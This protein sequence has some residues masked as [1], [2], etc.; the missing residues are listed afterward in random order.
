MTLIITVASPLFIIQV[1]DRLLTRAIA[2]KTEEFDANSNKSLI[3]E[4]SNGLLAISYCGKAFIDGKPTDEWI[5]MQ[6]HPSLKKMHADGPDPWSIQHGSLD[7]AHWLSSDGVVKRLR[8]KLSKLHESETKECGVTIVISGWKPN[9]PRKNKLLVELTRPRGSTKLVKVIGIKRKPG[10]KGNCGIGMVGSG[11][12]KETWAYVK[13]CWNEIHEGVTPP[14]SE[15]EYEAY[16]T[17]VRDAMVATVKF[18]ASIE[19]SV[20][21]NVHATTLWQPQYQR[22]LR[23]E[24]HF[25]STLPHPATIQPPSREVHVP[26]AAV[27][28]WSIFG[29][30]ICAPSYLVGQHSVSGS[31]TD[32]Q[33]SGT[34][35]QNGVTFFFKAIP[36]R[37]S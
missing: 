9:Q 21:P 3:Y 11:A 16:V 32:L 18:A 36:R 24:T 6:L 5:A 13:A 26:D 29:N 33:M 19:Q 34:P 8:E 20:G 2:G 31:F 22:P 1:G 12:R 23:A 15:A 10:I 27:T 17:T 4:A 37:R 25:F 30:V 28:G 7:P 35:A 14:Q